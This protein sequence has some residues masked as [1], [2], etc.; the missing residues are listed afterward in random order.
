M[1]SIKQDKPDLT[2]FGVFPDSFREHVHIL[3][4]ESYCFSL[5]KI[6]SDN[7]KE[8]DITGYIVEGIE[9]KF[10]NREAPK[11]CYGYAV[12]EDNPQNKQGYRG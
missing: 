10:R 9:Q 5:S 6:I 12:K 2:H 1:N 4:A 8:T 3:I 11:W 7:D